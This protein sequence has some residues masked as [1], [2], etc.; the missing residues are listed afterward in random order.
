MQANA[1]AKWRYLYLVFSSR[2]LGSFFEHILVMFKLKTTLFTE[3]FFYI[4]HVSDKRYMNQFGAKA[5]LKSVNLITKCE[6]KCYEFAW[7]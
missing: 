1:S 3:H 7:A 5:F 4:I 2:D 6:H